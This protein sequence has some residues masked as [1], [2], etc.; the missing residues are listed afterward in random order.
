M[1]Q[2]KY[3]GGTS[4]SG[5]TVIG[6]YKTGVNGCFTV[7][8]LKAGTYIVEELASD[9][10]HVI[11]TAPQTAY[12]SGKE[13]DVV[14]LYFGN[15]PKGALLVKKVDAANGILTLLLSV[16][17]FTQSSVAGIKRNQDG[18]DGNNREDTMNDIRV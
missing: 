2:V 11:D 5:G 13:Q 17:A 18:G 1:F 6:T 16:G 10:G 12:I 14:Q 9:S 7:T 3:L 4:G 15:S 8:G